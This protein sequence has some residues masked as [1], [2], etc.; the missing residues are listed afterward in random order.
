MHGKYSYLEDLAYSTGVQ[1]FIYGYPLI[2]VERTRQL[3]TV[4]D[5]P[6]DPPA[7]RS[8]PGKTTRSVLR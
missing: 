8:F 3:Q 7:H 4:T 5:I 2:A 1:A 6:T